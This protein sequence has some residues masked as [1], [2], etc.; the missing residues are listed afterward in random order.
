MNPD[1]LLKLKAIGFNSEPT[2]QN[3]LGAIKSEFL[4]VRQRRD[5]TFVADNQKHQIHGDTYEEALAN[6]IIKI[7]EEPIQP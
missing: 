6:L 5:G 3:L 4:E 1:I 7:H 2:Y